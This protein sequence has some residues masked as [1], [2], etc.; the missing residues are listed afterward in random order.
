MATVN[1]DGKRGNNMSE[2]RKPDSYNGT[3]SRWKTDFRIDR[4]YFAAHFCKSDLTADDAAVLDPPVG[5]NGSVTDGFQRTPAFFPEEI[6]ENCLSA[7][8]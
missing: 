3:R 4:Q 8:Q 5:K 7:E 2:N 1:S 6:L